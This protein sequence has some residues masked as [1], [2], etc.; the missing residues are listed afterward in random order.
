MHRI[1]LLFALSISQGCAGIKTLEVQLKDAQRERDIL[2]DAYEAQQLRLK[3]LESRLLKLED[4]SLSPTR[5]KDE[6]KVFQETVLRTKAGVQ[7]RTW[8]HKRLRSLPIVM[9]KKDQINFG[10]ESGYS[11]SGDRLVEKRRKLRSR[12]IGQ[13]ES[14][15]MRS[16]S[17]SRKDQR[18]KLKVESR[19]PSLSASNLDQYR[20]PDELKTIQKFEQERKTE[21]Q[22]QKRRPKGEKSVRIKRQSVEGQQILSAGLTASSNELNQ[23]QEPLYQNSNDETP[24]I[25][26]VKIGL[27]QAQS[28]QRQGRLNE[29]MRVAKR[30]IADSPTDPLIPDILYLMGR[31][32]IEQ[33][34]TT[35]GRSTLLRLSRLYPKATVAKEAQRF[36]NLE[37]S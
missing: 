18:K 7:Q 34:Q 4:S 27:K 20:D 13:K 31:L 26:P 2:R 14:S 3:E 12:S 23:V 33:G 11:D 6:P 5:V 30:L 29:A 32:Q 22:D 15:R 1:I 37:G 25:N 28:Y 8:P 17:N 9:V 16:T 24:L 35:A 10:R 19:P 36:L 21:K